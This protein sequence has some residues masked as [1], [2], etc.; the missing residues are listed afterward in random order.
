MKIF[1]KQALQN[2]EVSEN[3]PLMVAILYDWEIGVDL[4]KE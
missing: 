2:K 4:K 1:E 3:T